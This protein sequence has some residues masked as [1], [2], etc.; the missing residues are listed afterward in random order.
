MSTEKTDA[1]IIRQ[2]DYSETSKIVTFFTSEF[3]KVSAIAKGA[4]RLK[5]PFESAIDLLAVC[6]IVFIHKS[7]DS[8][9]ILTEAQMS[10]R[11]Q[12]EGRNLVR[13]YGGYYI[14]ELLDR[15]TEDFDPHPELYL[16]SLKTLTR[17]EKDEKPQL[18]II[19]FELTILREIGQLP[20]LNQCVSCEEAVQ[21]G[22]SYGFWISQGGLICPSCQVDKYQKDGIQAGT[23][24]V[25]RNLAYEPDQVI[26]R[27]DISIS[28]QKQIRK[29]IT[30]II[31]YTLGQRPKLLRYIELS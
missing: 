17:L 21:Q 13:L 22:K 23:I 4:K 1:L 2:V 30:S 6:K 11:F 15:L 25:L 18:A 31:S 26:S 19:R 27:L 5:G 29:I 14:A 12:P 3:G 8:L 24:A 10:K 20:I 9:D 7:S 16:E 28:Q